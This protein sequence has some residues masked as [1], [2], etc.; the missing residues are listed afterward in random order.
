MRLDSYYIATLSFVGF[1]AYNLLSLVCKYVLAERGG[2]GVFILRGRMQRREFIKGLLA[3]GSGIVIPST[4]FI[5]DYGA[6]S[7]KKPW[8]DEITGNNALLDYLKQSGHIKSFLYVNPEFKQRLYI[9]PPPNELIISCSDVIAS[10]DW[11]YKQ[12]I[13]PVGC[14]GGILRSS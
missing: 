2:I 10:V 7:Y 3:V 12:E 6:N 5:F 11:E 8:Q 9:S 1:T 4:K 13:A 14:F